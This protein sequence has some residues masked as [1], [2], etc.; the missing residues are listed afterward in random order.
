[1]TIHKNIQTFNL[2][3]MPILIGFG[4]LLASLFFTLT[5][6]ASGP[7]GGD[8]EGMVELSR[9][10]TPAQSFAQNGENPP[11]GNGGSGG[12]AQGGT[13]GYVSVT[14]PCSNN[15]L[16]GQGCGGVD[17]WG[18]NAFC[19]AV[20]G[21]G[22]ANVTML[23]GVTVIT[24]RGVAKAGNI[25]AFAYAVRPINVGTAGEEGFF[26]YRVD[27]RTTFSLGFH[28]GYPTWNASAA[29]TC[30]YN[31]RGLAAKSRDI[32]VIRANGT[33]LFSGA[34]TGPTARGPGACQE[35]ANPRLTTPLSEYSYYRLSVYADYT[36]WQQYRL[37]FAGTVYNERWDNVG[38]GTAERT[39]YFSYS[40]RANN[41]FNMYESYA[42]LAANPV[43]NFFDP[44]GCPQVNW[45]CELTDSTTV[46]IDRNTIAA[47]VTRVNNPVSVMRN[48]DPITMTYSR[49]N[50]LDTTNG[51]NVN[52]TEGQTGI[53]VRNLTSIAYRDMVK[54]R[55]SAEAEKN[56]I[57]VNQSAK[58]TPWNKNADINSSNQYFQMYKQGTKTKLNWDQWVSGSGVS[59]NADGNRNVDLTFNWSSDKG[60][61][62]VAMRNYRV[63]AE[64]LVPRG[65]SIGLDGNGNPVYTGTSFQWVQDTRLCKERDASGRETAQLLTAVSNPVEV[66]RSTNK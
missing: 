1:M 42:G 61:D 12:G 51:G 21:I 50:I 39:R 57:P 9:V 37:T 58:S 38:S 13:P 54:G 47:G 30:Y 14:A 64:F 26:E 29:K 65:S 63:T 28:C 60:S 43:P 22:A 15:P 17:P 35:S 16:L 31:Y 6:F 46:G 36:R 33:M 5:A 4:L 34:L 52:V 45:K 56:S 48:G 24:Y 44:S 25:P 20:N 53:G 11:A 32:G 19:P 55:G 49:V 23:G 66:I 62:F 10:S 27:T 7:G 59:A 18:G 3:P 8:Y 41:P 2:N 40:C